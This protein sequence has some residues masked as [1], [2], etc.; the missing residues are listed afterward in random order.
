[1]KIIL[2]KH[3]KEIKNNIKINTNYINLNNKYIDILKNSN[4]VSI[5]VRQNRY[6]ED[7]KT[8]NNSKSDRIY[9]RYN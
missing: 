9:Q 5:C 3:S 8:K 7:K 1:M 2:K 6:S 4:S